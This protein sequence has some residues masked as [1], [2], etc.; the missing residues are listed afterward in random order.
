MKIKTLK[1]GARR[2]S[3]KAIPSEDM[4][5][6]RTIGQIGLYTGKILID[7]T[8][9]PSSQAEVLIHEVL[10]GIF[11]DSGARLPRKKEEKLVRLLSPR[12]TAFLADNPAEIRHLLQMLK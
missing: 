2:Y 8:H 5:D 7:E 10:H 12:I 9:M 6:S 3:V 1:I 4:D 11:L